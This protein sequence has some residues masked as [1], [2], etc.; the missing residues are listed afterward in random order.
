V[1]L[2]LAVVP[3]PRRVPLAL[4]DGRVDYVPHHGGEVSGYCR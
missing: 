1:E 3:E 2:D 4:L